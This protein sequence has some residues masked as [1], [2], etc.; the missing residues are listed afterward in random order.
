M[1]EYEIPP[2]EYN[3]ECVLPP[4]DETSEW[5]ELPE[6]LSAKQRCENL[7]HR[8]PKK[9]GGHHHSIEV[10]DHDRE[11]GSPSIELLGDSE[12]TWNLEATGNVP[13]LRYLTLHL[14]ELDKFLSFEVTVL[15][16]EMKVRVLKVGNKRSHCVISNE[17]KL[18]ESGNEFEYR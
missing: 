10:I 14:K 5:H 16:E 7:I 8:G 18:D 9:S 1:A 13:I 4:N 2:E 17:K 6:Y 11:I 15:D 3:F 12:I